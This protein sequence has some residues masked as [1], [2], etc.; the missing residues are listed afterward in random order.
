MKIKSFA[1]INLTLN[2]LLTIIVVTLII[3]VIRST[4]TSKLENIDSKWSWYKYLIEPHTK[5]L[6]IPKKDI[7][8]KT[9][10]F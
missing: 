8:K 4:N 5:C 2:I 9:V 1:K 10:Y 7:F 6:N 3:G